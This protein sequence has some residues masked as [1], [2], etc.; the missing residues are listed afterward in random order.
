MKMVPSIQQGY[1]AFFTIPSALACLPSL[2]SRSLNP[3]A[4]ASGNDW[5]LK[6]LCVDSEK[7]L[8]MNEDFHEIGKALN[9]SL[10]INNLI[11]NWIVFYE[12]DYWSIIFIYFSLQRFF[13]WICFICARDGAALVVGSG[14]H[15]WSAVRAIIMYTRT[16]GGCAGDGGK[17]KLFFSFEV[18]LFF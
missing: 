15:W 11:F 17:G 3:P 9:Q 16:D 10:F 4:A 13:H 7:Y 5:S 14:G 1:S 18:F 8:N 2:V 12:I 6:T